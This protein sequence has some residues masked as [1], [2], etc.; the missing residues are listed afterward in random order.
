MQDT[1][2]LSRPTGS[3]P[4]HQPL[5]SRGSTKP[6]NRTIGHKSDSPEQRRD[7]GCMIRTPSP[8][9]PHTNVT[10]GPN[11]PNMATW[12]SNLGSVLQQLGGE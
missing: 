3:P 1:S 5:I 4:R 8:A 6:L 9:A 11:H 12:H 10:L 7:L 2:F